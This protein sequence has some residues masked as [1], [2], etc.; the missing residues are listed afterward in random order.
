MLDANVKSR[1][2]RDEEGNAFEVEIIRFLRGKGYSVQATGQPG[3]LKGAPQFWLP[4]SKEY[5]LSADFLAAKDGKL[6][7]IEA[8]KRKLYPRYRLF[9]GHRFDRGPVIYLNQQSLDG[10]ST[11]VERFNCADGIYAFELPDGDLVGQ[12]YR[13]LN[14]SSAQGHKPAEGKK[15]EAFIFEVEDFMPLGDLV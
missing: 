6:L 9:R 15:K 3:N 13:K 2:E 7:L 8:K 11:F 5:Y 12:T 10:V 14:A 4:D 1:E